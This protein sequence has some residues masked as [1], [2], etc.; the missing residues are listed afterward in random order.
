MF[1]DIE[2]KYKK[3]EHNFVFSFFYWI[4]ALGIA[5]IVLFISN[6]CNFTNHLTIIIFYIIFIITNL[7]FYKYYYKKKYSYKKED[8]IRGLIKI[9]N[10]NNIRIKSDIKLAI[11]YYNSK[12]PLK[13]E[14][15]FLAWIVSS[16]IS[17]AS[18]VEIAYDKEENI[19]NY[20]K[21]EVVLE[22]TLGFIF[23]IIIPLIVI[24]LFLNSFDIPKKE[25]YSELTDDLSYIYYNHNKYKNELQKNKNS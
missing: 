15:S 17:M 1:S 16:I 14:S 8:K 4:S 25:I 10:E 6:L 11:D 19:I 3:I 9:L 2:K 22:S 13:I 18:L 24:K 23:V 21:L 20:K 12:L 7:L 5:I